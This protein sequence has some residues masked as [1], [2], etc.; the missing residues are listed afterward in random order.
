MK[1]V[2]RLL[3]FLARGTDEYRGAVHPDSW[4]AL[5]RLLTDVFR[6]RPP[7]KL[8]R[9]SHLIYSAQMRMSQQH[10]RWMRGGVHPLGT[11]A[12]AEAGQARF[13]RRTQIERRVTVLR[14]S[15]LH[16][17]SEHYGWAGQETGG[18]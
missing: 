1:D 12:R 4:L 8:S 2:E 13:E 16:A 6:G 7:R 9:R 14:D 3:N 5:N 11:R 15:I 18:E 10:E 17:C